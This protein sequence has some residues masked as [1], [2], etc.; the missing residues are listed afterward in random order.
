MSDL[1]SFSILVYNSGHRGVDAEMRVEF[2]V[3][4]TAADL[5]DYML[6]HTY[7]GF[8][9]LFGSIV[10]ALFIVM[11][12]NMGQF[13]YL[14]AGAVILL[15]IPCS[16]FL[17]AH[18]QVVLNEVFKKPL[19]YVLTDEG[20]TV[21]QDGNELFQEWDVVYR[22]KSTNRSLLIY[23]SKVNAWIFPKKAL[24]KDKDAVIQLISAHVAP[25]KIKIKQ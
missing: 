24:G 20:V 21:S 1:V 25:E 4:I 5:Y 14:I 7:S 9:G 18:K 19:H 2:D 13:I 16:L 10:G 6:A 12:F 23:T 11:Y 15:Y 8:S 22:A 3:K 17:R